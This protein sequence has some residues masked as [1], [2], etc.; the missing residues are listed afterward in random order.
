[1]KRKVFFSF[2]YKSDITRVSRIRNSGVTNAEGQSFLD[3]AEWEKVKKNGNQ[4]IKN[5]I[6]KN[7]SGTSVLV[8]CI[9]ETT[10]DSEWVSYEIQR[11][12]EQ[13]KGILG[14][15]LNGMKNLSG[16]IAR[17]G[18]NPINNI[19]GDIYSV[20]L[21]SSYKTYSWVDDDGNNNIKDWI[22]VA[23]KTAGK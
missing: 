3:K 12:H 5:W 2:Q 19:T 7:M 6:N 22:E 1:M 16:S 10:S 17:K 21:K 8:V 14:I 18:K 11:A 4:A 20:L 23:A 13:G 9:G 15:Y